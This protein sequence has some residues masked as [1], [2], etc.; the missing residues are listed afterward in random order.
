MKLLYIHDVPV[1]SEEANIIGVVQM[2][3]AFANN[4]VDVVLAVPKIENNDNKDFYIQVIK[5]KVGVD[6]NFSIVTFRKVTVCGKLRFVGGYLGVKSLLKTNKADI[7]FI[8]RASFVGLVLKANIPVVYESHNS[9]SHEG[10]K[11]LNNFWTRH[12]IKKSNQNHFLK[13][14]TISNALADYW[15]TK[16]IPEDKILVSHDGFDHKMFINR[17]K[18]S[19]ARKELG[20]PDNQKIVLY[21]G[22]LYRDRGIEEIIQL[23]QCF[24]DVL[25]M[26]VGGS[27]K[28]RKYYDDL[29][30]KK[31]TNNLHFKGRIPHYQVP[32]YLFAADIL[33]MVWT[34]KVKTINYCSP[35]KMF[36]YMAAGRIIV[37]HAFPTIKEVLEDRESALLADP[38][39]FN[40]LK[41]KLNLA[42]ESNSIETI[43]EKARYLAFNKY[44]WDRRAKSI[45]DQL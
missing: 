5:R 19:V 35:L 39:S 26:V 10:L 36:E 40:E 33:L 24:K 20:L 11:I 29:A 42:L 41:D 16:G 6:T 34:N 27:K 45:I 30:Q 1:D 8:R 31:N 37:G 32:D 18:K 12:V 43:A 38:D 13:F 3:H 2:C 9:L 44:S 23:A 4:G 28:E 21:V 7:C 15:K 17:K 22:S 25:F 14:I